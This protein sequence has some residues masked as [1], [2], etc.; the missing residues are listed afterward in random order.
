M[1]VDVTAVLPAVTDEVAALVAALALPAE[2][3]AALDPVDAAA[4]A[5]LDPVDTAALDP[6]ETT[7][8]PAD[9]TFEPNDTLLTPLRAANRAFFPAAAPVSF[10]VTSFSISSNFFSGEGVAHSTSLCFFSSSTDIVDLMSL[11]PEARR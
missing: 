11:E 1:A 4:L 9:T 2:A 7:F 3:A 6:T 10:I 8:C 5:A